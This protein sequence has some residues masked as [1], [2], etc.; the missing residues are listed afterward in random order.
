MKTA[1]PCQIPTTAE[2]ARD[3][4]LFYCKLFDDMVVGDLCSLRRRDLKDRDRF[5]CSGCSKD[6]LMNSPHNRM[7]MAAAAL[8]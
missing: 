7:R 1:K 4:Y 5:S 2:C 8:R 6:T 3:D